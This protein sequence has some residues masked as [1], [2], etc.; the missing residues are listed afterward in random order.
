MIKDLAE[1]LSSNIK[2]RFTSPLL[3]AY[4]VALAFANWKFLV[5]A[6]TSKNHSF[7]LIDELESVFPGALEAFGN[8]L[9]FALTFSLLYPTIKSWIGTLTSIAKIVDLRNESRVVN[10]REKLFVKQQNFE[11][12]TVDSTI[13]QL[14]DLVSEDRL[15]YH[16]LKRILDVLPSEEDLRINRKRDEFIETKDPDSSRYVKHP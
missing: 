4:T 6:F 3:G 13:S 2:E 1:S 11:Q 9:L 12:V 5:I 14:T 10:A 15:G 8:P 16:D 7:Q